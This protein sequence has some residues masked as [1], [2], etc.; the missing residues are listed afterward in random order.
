MME[1]R[2]SKLEAKATEINAQEEIINLAD[3]WYKLV[4]QQKDFEAALKVREKAQ[5][6]FEASP[7][8]ATGQPYITNKSLHIAWPWFCNYIDPATRKFYNNCAQHGRIGCSFH[9][10]QNRDNG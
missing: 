10:F 6:F 4:W 5:R 7:G 1:D 3:Q 2:I 8:L 9:Q